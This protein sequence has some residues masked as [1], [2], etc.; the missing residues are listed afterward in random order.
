MNPGAEGEDGAVGPVDIES[1]GFMVAGRVAVRGPDDRQHVRAL[2]NEQL[3]YLSLAQARAGQPE[4][5]MSIPPE[6]FPDNLV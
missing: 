3:P 5:E 2:R 4:R 6:M 1:A